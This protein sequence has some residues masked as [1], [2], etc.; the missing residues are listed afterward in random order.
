MSEHQKETA[1]L[2]RLISYGDN[3]QWRELD[4]R[5]RQLERDELCLRRAVWIMGL[6]AA[7]AAAGLCYSVVFLFDHTMN[8][9]Q[10]M[11][12]TVIKVLSAVALGSLGCA[13]AFRGLAIFYRKDLD[14]HREQCR[15][16]A[17]ELIESRLGIEPPARSEVAAR[18]PVPHAPAAIIATA[19]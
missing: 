8:A 4:N 16:L 11:T 13:F 14:Q 1:F 17:M 6:C 2:R 12:Q 19:G 10:F 15:R 7:L 5:I 9:T 3:A 18:S